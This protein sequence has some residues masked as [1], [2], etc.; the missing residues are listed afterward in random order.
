M[1]EVSLVAKAMAAESA[2]HETVLDGREV[3]KSHSGNV[4]IR[5]W[6]N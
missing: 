3:R 6:L 5:L 4:T 1:F 2:T